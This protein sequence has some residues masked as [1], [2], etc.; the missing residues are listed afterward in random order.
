MGSVRGNHPSQSKQA[1]L[2]EHIIAG[3]A[4]RTAVRRAGVQNFEV[5]WWMFGGY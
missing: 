1:R 3:A 2:I 5:A 4:I